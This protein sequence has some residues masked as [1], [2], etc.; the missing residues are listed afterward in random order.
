MTHPMNIRRASL[1]VESIISCSKESLPEVRGRPRVE[2][3]P[4][5]ET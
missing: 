1:R 5:W 4:D 3:A 2:S